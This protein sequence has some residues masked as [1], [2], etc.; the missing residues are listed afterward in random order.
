MRPM[1]DDAVRDVLAAQLQQAVQV[2]RELLDLIDR[3]WVQISWRPSDR[4]VVEA[5][6]E[7]LREVTK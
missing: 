1:S 7:F 3:K 4:Q 5:A 6:R 2:V